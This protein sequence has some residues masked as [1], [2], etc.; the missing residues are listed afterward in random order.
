MRRRHW[1]TAVGLAV[2]LMAFTTTSAYA[3]IPYGPGPV[4]YT[5]QPQPLPGTCHYRFTSTHQPLPDTRCTPGAL[6]PKVSQRSLAVTVCH[7]GYT[8][9]I[10]PSSTITGKEKVANAASYHYTGSLAY[11]EYDHLISLELGGDPNDRR[12]LWVEPPSPGHTASQGVN[13]PKDATENYLKALV[14]NYVHLLSHHH[15]TAT[16]Y[17]PLAAAQNLIAA[18]WTTARA[19]APRYLIRG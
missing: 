14:C 11:A 15:G 13:N 6:N 4:R 2:V 12:N 16:S 5:V 17:L 18:N 19:S 9:S 1:L 10:R 8:T 7:T 3:A